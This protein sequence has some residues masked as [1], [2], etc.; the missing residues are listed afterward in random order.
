M[1]NQKVVKNFER[2]VFAPVNAW[3]KCAEIFNFT[4]GVQVTKTIKRIFPGMLDC[5]AVYPACAEGFALVVQSLTP[6]LLDL[7]LHPHF[8][9]FSALSPIK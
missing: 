9:P 1:E 4:H 5:G 8:S 2:L 6:V 3:C 7:C